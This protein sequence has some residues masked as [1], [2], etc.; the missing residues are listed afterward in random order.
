[1]KL[2]GER[3]IHVGDDN[4]FEPGL[5]LTAWKDG[6]NQPEIR[7]GNRCL[8]RNFCHITAFNQVV[9]GDDLLTGTNVLITDNS[10]GGTDHAMLSVPPRIRPLVSKGRVVIGNRVWLGNNV[11]VLPGV[12]IGDGAVVGANSVVTHDVPANTVV[13]GIP[14]VIVN[15]KA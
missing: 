2:E 9:I 12:T 15:T 3:Y 10:H 4:V 1:M 8:F 6:D 14:A 13:A 7:I 5:Q 11:C